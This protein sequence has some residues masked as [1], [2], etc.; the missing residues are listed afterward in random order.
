[1]SLSNENMIS[2]VKEYYFGFDIFL[3]ILEYKYIYQNYN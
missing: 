1:M 3:W 2:T